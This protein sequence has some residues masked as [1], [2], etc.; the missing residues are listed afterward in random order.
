MTPQEARLKPVLSAPPARPLPVV[1][2]V[3]LG[4]VGLPLALAFARH[5]RT[6]GVDPAEV[7]LAAYRRK[8]DPSGHAPDADFAAATH[9]E[10]TADPAA[11]AAAELIMVAVPTPVDAQGEPDFGALTAACRSIGRH[12]RRG[13]TVVFESTVYPGA[14]EDVCVPLLEQA[15]G[16][17]WK[18]GFFVAYS[19]ERINPGDTVHT[20]SR[21]R[22][23]VAGDTPATLERVARAYETIVEAGVA[24]VASIRVAETAKIVE[25]AQRDVNIAFANEVA[26]TCHGLGLDSIAVLEAAG[27]KWNFLPFRP[28]LVGGDCVGV[29]S[30]MIA[31][32]A[33]ASGRTAR[34]VSAARRVNDGIGPWVADET[35]RLL[36]EGGRAP[37]GVPIV[38]LGLAF[39]EDV[40]DLRNTK[41]VDIVRRLREQGA[42]VH[43]HDPVASRVDAMA[44]YG[45]RLADWDTLPQAAAVIVAVAHREYR[46]LAPAALAARLAPNGVVADLKGICDADRLRALGLR[47]WRL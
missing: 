13:A 22:K 44:R 46:A 32:A 39:K 5:G 29:A 25:N 26:L 17:R 34:L 47:V 16:M 10:L 4:Y 20:L 30:H 15:S 6:I 11:L 28:G 24:R 8:H 3:G 2:V 38:V 33:R 36:A 31:H 41:V 1:A 45:I 23:L 40:T 12:L 18:D 21:V 14:T 42:D 27:T 9:L 35:L 43:V 7:K 19:P 37:E